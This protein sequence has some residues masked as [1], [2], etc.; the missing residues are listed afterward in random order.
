MRVRRQP[1]SRLM[2]LIRP[3]APVRQRTM[4]WK[5]VRLRFGA[6][7]AGSALAGDAHPGN[8]ELGQVVVDRGQPVEESARH[9]ASVTGEIHH[10]RRLAGNRLDDIGEARR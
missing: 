4:R 1:T 9:S 3:S 8:S 10:A 5:G 7:G 2:Q 6:G